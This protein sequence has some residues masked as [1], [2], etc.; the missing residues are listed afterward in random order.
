MRLLKRFFLYGATFFFSVNM[1]SAFSEK[2][3]I[4]PQEGTFANMQPLVLNVSDGEEVYYSLSSSDPSVS[5]FSYDGPVLVE[6]TGNIT[7]RITCLKDDV[8]SDFQVNF[9]VVPENFSTMNPDAASFMQNVVLASVTDYYSGEK[10][11]IPAEFEYTL[12]HSV[13]FKKA[14]TLSIPSQNVLE[15]YVPL[16]VKNGSSVWAFVL[17]VKPSRSSKT[18]FERNVPFKISDWDTFVFTGKNLIYCLDDS[19]WSADTQPVKLDRTV[20]HVVKWQSMDYKKGNPVS[21]FQ[22]P[23]RPQLSVEAE[24]SSRCVYSFSEKG[25]ELSQVS[26]VLTDKIA[27]CAFNGEEIDSYHNVNVYY[28]NVFQGKLPVNFYIDRKPPAKPVIDTN[29]KAAYSRSEVKVTV[30]PDKADAKNFTKITCLVSLPV[31]TESGAL[32]ETISEPSELQFE[33]ASANSFTLKSKGH[34]P[35]YYKVMAWAEDERGNRSVTSSYE[36]VV[37]QYNYYISSSSESL[38]HDGSFLN[39]F[40]TFEEAFAF[41]SDEG[42]VNYLH[43]TGDFVIDKNLELKVP[44]IIDSQAANVVLKNDAFL[45]VSGTSF[46]ANNIF[47]SKESTS[48]KKDTPIFYAKN[49]VLEFNGCEVSGVYVKSGVLIDLVNSTLKA[50]DSGFTTRGSAYALNVSAVDTS[51]VIKDSRFTSVARSAV[52]LN[53]TGGTLVTLGSDYY[54]VG[55]LGRSIELVEADASLEENVFSLE[56][57]SKIKGASYLYKDEKSAVRKDFHNIVRGDN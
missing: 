33:K 45:T 17:H 16:R 15:R 31:E 24:D 32:K 8:R 23:P 26:Q 27:A 20:P 49:A 55:T 52:N 44:L 5:G 22:L 29:A 4:S 53:V 28:A 57:D 7:L 46:S 54:V 18:F 19:L 21:E 14:E 34:S 51:T 30:S 42:D 13:D 2:D 50:S 1:L 36:V 9:N 11:V 43:A 35:T 39:P 3:I 10:F 38:R 6:S 12:G 47:F 41:L 48:E 56:L 25:F 40:T 37:D